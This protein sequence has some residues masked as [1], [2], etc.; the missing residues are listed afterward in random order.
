MAANYTEG[1]ANPII[2]ICFLLF[3]AYISAIALYII[4]FAA[5]AIAL[6]RAFIMPLTLGVVLPAL[7]TLVLVFFL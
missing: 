3:M 2:V 7:L 5:P 6:I 4:T 1:Q